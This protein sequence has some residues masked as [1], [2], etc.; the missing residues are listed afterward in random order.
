MNLS[1]LT[2]VELATLLKKRE[3]SLFDI[4]SALIKEKEKINSYNAFISFSDEEKLLEEAKKIE[5]K[6]LNKKDPPPLAGIPLAVKDNICTYDLPTTC[7]S[8]ILD[9]YHSN[10]DAT[11]VARARQ[12]GMLIVGKTNLDEFAMGSSCETSHFGPTLNIHSREHVPGGSSG[13]SAVVVAAGVTPL[14][15]GSDTGGSVRQPASFCG[16]VGLKPTYGRLSRFGLVA[17]ASSLD[18]IGIFSRNIPDCA[19][20]LNSIG[21]FDEKDFTSSL[22][23]KEDYFS[24]LPKEPT[25][26]NREIKIGVIKEYLYAEGVE[27]EVREKIED[28]IKLWDKLGAK[29][30]EI[31]LEYS[32]YA[33][34]CY[35]IIATSE[36]SSNLAR[37]DGM[38]YGLRIQGDTLSE[39]YRKT[40]NV[41]FGSEVKRR[42]L[43]GTFCLSAG[44]Y[45][46]YYL[47]A[48]K[49]RRKIKEDY[50]KALNKCDLLLSPT[51]PTVAF[52][53]GEKLK[54]PL[55]MYLS[56]VFTVGANL[57]GLPA[58]SIPCGYVDKGNYKLPVGMQIIAGHFKEKL[59]LEATAAFELLYSK[60]S[61]SFN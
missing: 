12:Q 26:K 3:I 33:L 56:D 14:A 41:G 51:S 46:A 31:S 6:F 55:K 20:L 21:G 7:G 60:K 30:E 40:R 22:Q 54:D 17:F 25:L 49:L 43:L 15:L 50:A 61:L 36:A 24:F 38:R 5:D 32:D 13:G 39:V 19:L 37:Y 48:Q 57:A 1:S 28:S 35:Y 52:K 53:L 23:E 34:A 58:I 11:V 10:Y 2:A 18:H 59:L 45:D 27:R 47:Q 16:V 9:N 44:Y 4:I 29:I 8:A 42:I